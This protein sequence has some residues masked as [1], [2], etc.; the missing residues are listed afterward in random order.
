MKILIIGDPHGFH[1]YKESILRQ[2]DVILMTGDIG[3]ADIARKRSFENYEREKKGLPEKEYTPK[4]NRESSMEI[5]NST[6]KIV[7]LL[8]KFVPV[9]TILGNV[10]S[11]DKNVKKEEKKLGIKIPHLVFDMKKIKN[12]NI[13]KNSIRKINGFRIGFL[14]YFTDTN[15]VRD[16]K[17]RDYKKKMKEARKES[18]K[19]KRILRRFGDLDILICHQPPYG[20]LDKVSSK[21]SPPKSWVGK[22]AGSKVILDYVKKKQPRYVF[23]AHIHEGKGKVKIGRTEVYNVGH[24]GNYIL[25]DID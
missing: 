11:T 15:W 24:N 3:K 10:W 21:Y 17:P 12:F 2:A 18:D 1:K 25:L 20:I 19:A 14:E 22:H 6:M 7:R 5:Y 4:Q 13:V 9:Y 8:S 23:C 16:F